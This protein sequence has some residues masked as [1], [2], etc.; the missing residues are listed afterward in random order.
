MLKKYE[1]ATAY[2]MLALLIASLLPVIYLGRYN[3]PTGDDYYYGGA[4]KVV[5]EETGSILETVAE[6]VRGVAY[7][8]DN[9]QGTYS[10]MLLMYLPPNIFGDWA[11]RCITGTLL[12]LLV[13]SIFY[14]ARP[15][16]RSLLKGSGELWIIISSLLSLL[17]V[18]TVPSQGETFFWYN[19]SMYYTGYYAVTL[20]LFGVILRY[21]T[22]PRRYHLISMLVLPVFLAGGNY[23]SLLPAIILSV[24][25]TTA[26]ICKH[27]EKA[28]GVGM[29]AVLLLVFFG[30][31]AA[32]PG[33]AVRQ[34]DMW[35]IPAWKAIAKSLLQGIRYLLAWIRGWWV[36]AAVI[37]TPFLWKTFANMKFRFRYPLL[38]VGLAYGSFCSMSC[39]TFYTMNSTGPARAVAIVYYGF[40]LFTFVSYGYLLG[41][42]YR[43]VEKHPVRWQRKEVQGERIPISKIHEKAKNELQNEAELNVWEQDKPEK[44]MGQKGVSPSGET[45][46]KYSKCLPAAWAAAILI[47]AGILSLTGQA[48]QLTTTKAIRLLAS[49]EA[50]AYEQEY[51]ER[52]R[53]LEDDTITDVVLEPYQNQPDMLYVGDLTGDAQDDTNQ[54]AAQYFGKNTVRV[55]YD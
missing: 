22:K 6:A 48:S 35:K 26:L 36:W 32:A 2:I 39:P 31:S 1:K 28:W 41:Y 21:L 7:Q 11:Y 23:V 17:C 30:V 34:S 4:T 16:V 45:W 40:L 37:M 53:I 18:Q 55:D 8:Y 20:F 9:W 42:V 44:E 51:Q 27:S 38:V 29:V 10:A 33:N 49:G 46:S 25:L 13:G 47:L 50:K 43:F 19:G 24:L 52:L 12:L 54:K 5:W 3:H 14:L 15:I